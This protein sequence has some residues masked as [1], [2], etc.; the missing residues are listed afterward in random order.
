MPWCK[1]HRNFQYLHSSMHLASR[2]LW[3][4]AKPQHL[5]I[6]SAKHDGST[7]RMWPS[8]S[9]AISS[10][11]PQTQRGNQREHTSQ[12]SLWISMQSNCLYLALYTNNNSSSS[13]HLLVA[14][15]S[16]PYLQWASTLFLYWANSWLPANLRGNALICF[17]SKHVLW[18]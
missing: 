16:W 7:A 15:T 6:L 18:S 9:T 11:I 14:R 8:A 10:W 12:K 1:I 3:R 5:W 4:K 13:F 17:L 2:I